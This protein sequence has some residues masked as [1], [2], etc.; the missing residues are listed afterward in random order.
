MSKEIELL[1]LIS[2]QLMGIHIILSFSMMALIVIVIMK[3][4]D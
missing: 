2:D 4:S 3:I 1:Q